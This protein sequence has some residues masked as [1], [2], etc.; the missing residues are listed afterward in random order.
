MERID[1][2]S[3]DITGLHFHQLEE[4]RTRA[5]HRITEIRETGAPTLREQWAVQAAAIGLTIDEIIEGGKG[6]RGRRRVRNGES[7]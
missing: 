7:G 1:P 5:E 3:I 2:E 6:R 4:L